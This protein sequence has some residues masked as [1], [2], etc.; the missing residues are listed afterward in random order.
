M[1][2]DCACSADT[3]RSHKI[4]SVVHPPEPPPVDGSALPCES[5]G[6][7]FSFK[8]LSG[9]DITMQIISRARFFDCIDVPLVVPTHLCYVS[10]C[11]K[12]RVDR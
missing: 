8:R 6:S 5:V 1:R 2:G 11:A 3:A 10:L 7:N 4:Q 12:Y 9:R